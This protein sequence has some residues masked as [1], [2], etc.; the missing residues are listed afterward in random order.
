MLNRAETDKVAAAGAHLAY[1]HCMGAHRP[2]PAVHVPLG[3]ELRV[4]YG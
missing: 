1:L 2:R 4:A 3:V